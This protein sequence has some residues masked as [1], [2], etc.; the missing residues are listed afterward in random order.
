MKFEFEHFSLARGDT[1][2][3]EGVPVHAGEHG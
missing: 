3:L 1:E 2:L